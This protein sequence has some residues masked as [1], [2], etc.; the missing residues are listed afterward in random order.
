MC[1]ALKAGAVSVAVKDFDEFSL[2]HFG[3]FFFLKLSLGFKNIS[4][5]YLFSPQKVTHLERHTKRV[6]DPPQSSS[7]SRRRR[8]R[9][10]KWYVF[11]RSEK[12]K[13]RER[14][15]PAGFRRSRTDRKTAGP[16]IRRA[17]ICF[18][19]AFSFVVSRAEKKKI[20][21]LGPN[22]TGGGRC[23]RDL[24]ARKR[25][26]GEWSSDEENDAVVVA[27]RWGGGVPT[28]RIPMPFFLFR[29]GLSLLGN[30]GKRES[31]KCFGCTTKWCLHQL[32][33]RRARAFDDGFFPRFFLRTL[34]TSQRTDDDAFFSHSST[35]YRSRSW[36]PQQKDE[37]HQAKV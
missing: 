4:F 21:R 24:G 30:R 36:R 14:T 20:G 26:R 34:P 2:E 19:R 6:Q 11:L 28:R 31:K 22:A 1:V 15:R 23:D 13:R 16:P 29:L 12:Q 32:C 37:A 7:S 27:E 5:P 3:L 33:E 9:R 25:F 18:I 35:G 17:K 8:R 10:E